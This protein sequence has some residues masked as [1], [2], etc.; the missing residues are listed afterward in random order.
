MLARKAARWAQDNAEAIA[1]AD[2]KMPDGIINRRPTTGG[3]CSP[4][5]MRPAGTGR[6][7]RARRRRHIA[8]GGDEASRLELLLGDIRDAFA[9]DKATK[10]RD[11][12][13]A[14]Q[15]EISSADLVDA[16]VKV[17]GHPWA[18]MGKARKPMTQNRLARMLMTALGIRPGYIGP[19]TE[20]QARLASASTSKRRSSARFAPGGGSPAIVQVCRSR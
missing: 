19:E 18:E 1:E 11:M 6:S 8:A 3:R 4:S 16:L 14:E 10:A 5:L 13:G 7:V 9:T 2:P 15:I 17:E 12:F 20:A